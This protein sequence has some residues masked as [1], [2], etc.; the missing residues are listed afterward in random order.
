M[1]LSHHA[2]KSIK[3]A[4]LVACTRCSVKRDFG[5]STGNKPL[6]LAFLE[7]VSIT[8]ILVI[9]VPECPA[10]YA[11]LTVSCTA[12]RACLFML[13]K[14]PKPQARK[15]IYAS[16][17]FLLLRLLLGAKS[18][19]IDNRYLHEIETREAI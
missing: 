7:R 16:I 17:A 15:C 18:N 5:S 2:G 11:V 12:M 8:I 19:R 4:V 13:S 14:I 10:L 9:V 3:M 6:Q 1:Q